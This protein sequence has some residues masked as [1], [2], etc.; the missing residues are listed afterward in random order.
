MSAIVPAHNAGDNMYG[1]PIP[2][3]TV[4]PVPS[5]RDWSAERRGWGMSYDDIS[6]PERQSESEE[7]DSLDKQ[8]W[9]KAVPHANHSTP[10]FWPPND[11]NGIVTKK[12]IANEILDA[13]PKYGRAKAEDIAERVWQ[14]RSGKCVQVFTILVLLDKVD[15]LVEHILGCRH[16]V[17]DHDLPL[18]LKGRQGSHSRKLCRANSEAVCCFSRW[19]N[20]NLELF[21]TFQRRLAVPVFSLDRRNNA[22]IHLELDDKDILPW[23]EEAEVPPV[24]AMSGGSGTVIRVKIHPRCH[25]F[26]N[27]LSAVSSVIS[28]TP[29]SVVS[30][31]IIDKCRRWGL[32]CQKAAAEDLFQF[33]GRSQRLEEIQWK[34]PPAPRHASGDIHSRAILPHDLPM[35]RV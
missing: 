17:R 18:I 9:Q 12:A 3:I 19:K 22:L 23:C 34:G 8:L 20:A 1:V 5:D 29:L 26:H 13:F 30:D 10:S 6:V 25:E 11:L 16:G 32:C 31:M 28:Q 2:T 27:T 15:V 4:E 7:P 21:D 24:S 33:Q 35:G 14:D